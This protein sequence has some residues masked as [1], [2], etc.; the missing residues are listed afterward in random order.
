MPKAERYNILSKSLSSLAL[1]PERALAGKSFETLDIGALSHF[2]LALCGRFYPITYKKLRKLSDTQHD[3][4]F[5]FIKALLNALEDND[6]NSQINS[7]FIDIEKERFVWFPNL[8]R[9]LVRHEAVAIVNEYKFKPGPDKGSNKN[10]RLR[11]D[12][13]ARALDL[14]QKGIRYTQKDLAAE[15]EVSPQRMSILLRELNL[16]V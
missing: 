8:L 2:L 5:R 13:E 4:K 14:K 9:V 6:C 3:N 15:F 11:L 10:V 12:I 16:K 1:K 7:S